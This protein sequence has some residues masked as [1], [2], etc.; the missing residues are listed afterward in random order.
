MKRNF[1]I[2]SLL[3]L[4][5]AGLSAQNNPMLEN[6]HARKWQF[7]VD[8]AKLSAQE[9][10]RVQPLFMEFEQ[11]S[12]KLMEQNKNTFKKFRDARRNNK[13]VNYKD[14]NDLIVN[15]EIQK[16][17]LYKQ[18]YLKLQKVLSDETIFN[19]MNA[20]RL[21]RKELMNGWRQDR[22]EPNQ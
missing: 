16:A 15:G 3:L 1:I 17:H 18:Y 19:Y 21:F 4:I 10:A 22:P 5:Y 2:I 6:L 13:A 14:V 8:K 20:E 11:A 9:A 12:W 7:M